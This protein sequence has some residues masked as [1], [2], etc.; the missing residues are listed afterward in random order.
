MEKNCDKNLEF[1]KLEE[2][3]QNLVNLFNLRPIDNKIFVKKNGYKNLFWSVLLL[4]KI[5]SKSAYFAH[6][7][8]KTNY[9]AEK[10]LDKFFNKLTNLS[11]F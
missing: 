2:I 3:L 5:F 11:I 7:F 8:F 4:F 6:L 9:T 10:Y 1:S